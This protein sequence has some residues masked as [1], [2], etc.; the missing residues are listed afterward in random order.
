MEGSGLGIDIKLM[1]AQT[2]NFVLFWVLFAKFVAPK[3]F[4]FVKKQKAD[5]AERQALLTNLQKREDDAKSVA[6]GIVKEARSQAKLV[7]ADSVK[8]AK[9]AN[10]KL[11]QKAQ[12]E[13][14]ELKQKAKLQLQSQQDSMMADIKNQV[15]KTSQV[16][17]ET[18][19][20]DV[21]TSAEQEKI[22]KEV[23]S[24]LPKVTK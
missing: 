5:E 24:K 9:M 20:K 12:E 16:M 2:I 7:L 8:N 22:M 6:D 4:A 15:I 1:L 3:F 21:I 13:V 10:D 14:S 23:V 11:M 18:V 19:L 17:V